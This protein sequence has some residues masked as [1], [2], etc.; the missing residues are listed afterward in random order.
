ML[1]PS[2]NYSKPPGAGEAEVSLIGPGFGEAV[3]IHLGDGDWAL[4][5]SCV[6]TGANKPASLTYLEDIGADFDRVRLIAVSHWDDDH[7]RGLSRLVAACPK[8]EIVISNAL[9]GKEFL[10]YAELHRNP[11]ANRLK[12]GVSEIPDMLRLLQAN[13]TRVK[14]A[15]ESA[16]I[17][18][19]SAYTHGQAVEV[20]TLSPSSFEYTNFLN[21]LVTQIP[22]P[23]ETRRIA[24]SR[25]RNDLSTVIYVQVGSD[26]MLFGGDLEEEGKLHTGWSAILGNA[27]RPG[28]LASLFKVPHHGSETGDHPDVWSRMLGPEPFAILAP[29]QKG[30]HSIPGG[31]QVTRILSRTPNAFSSR[32]LAGRAR[33]RLDPAVERTIKQAAKSFETFD[34]TPGMIRL[35]RPIGSTAPWIPELFNAVHLS[36]IYE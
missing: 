19:S 10:T 27:T 3:L 36:K 33:K 31:T 9:T 6:A 23:K 20:W 29:F 8:A 11:L 34:Q 22:S 28:G 16:R 24:V 4:V 15:S 26:A 12:G 25:I 18:A 35:R 21:W 7:I 1:F 17:L 14:Y 5:D 32:S 13:P 2:P 30:R